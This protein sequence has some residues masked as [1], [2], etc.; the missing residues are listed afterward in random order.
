[1]STKPT[2]PVPQAAQR[3]PNAWAVGLTV[4]ASVILVVLAFFQ[5]LVGVAAIANDTFVIVGEKYI[6][7]FDITLWGWL[8]VA[9][10]VLMGTAAFF[11]YKGA[12]WARTVAVIAASI[13]AIANFAWLPHTPVWSILIIALDIAVIWAVTA[14]GRDITRA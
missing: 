11:L 14:R 5:A 6:F 12:V 9:L 4:F 8:H 3:E 13:S 10:A 2:R 7:T 1:M